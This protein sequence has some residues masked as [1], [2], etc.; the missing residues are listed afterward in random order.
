[1]F[2]REQVDEGGADAKPTDDPPTYEAEHG[3]DS[4]NS[5]GADSRKYGE[6]IRRVDLVKA[7]EQPASKLEANDGESECF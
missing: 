1:M 4:E 6:V 3:D 7:I 5:E 2:I